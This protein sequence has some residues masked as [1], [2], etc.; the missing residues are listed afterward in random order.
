MKYQFVFYCNRRTQVCA[1]NYNM[2]LQFLHPKTL[3]ISLQIHTGYNI[4]NSQPW[5]PIIADHGQLLGTWLT[6]V[7]H[8][9]PWSMVNHGRWWRLINGRWLK[10]FDHDPTTYYI[11][12]LYHIINLFHSFWFIK[13]MVMQKK[14]IYIKNYTWISST[15]YLG[16]IHWK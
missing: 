2:Y 5:W 10:K 3:Y 15:L 11:I 16:K 12:D 7:Y 13:F 9:L 1:L 8:F 4:F 6:M 14:H